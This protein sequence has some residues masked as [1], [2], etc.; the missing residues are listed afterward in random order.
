MITDLRRKKR[1]I[2]IEIGASDN[3]FE[4]DKLVD[5]LVDDI[6]IIC[7]QRKLPNQ[8]EIKIILE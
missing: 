1:A 5:D 3:P 4:I 7:E 8:T 2:L 6:K